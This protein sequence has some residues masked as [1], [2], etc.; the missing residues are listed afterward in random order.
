M[1]QLNHTYNFVTLAP[2]ILGGSYSLVKV[3]AIMSVDEASKYADVRS[4]H[5]TLQSQID[6]LPDI[7][8]CTFL[9]FENQD[10]HTTVLANEWIDQQSINVVDKVS[11][12]VIL[13]DINSE[14]IPL[15]RNQFLELG[16]TNINISIV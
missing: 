8:S 14:D 12:K 1:L 5:S 2:T 13:P 10:K 11:V 3:K 9:L 16:Y 4:I 15:I 6:S 7:N